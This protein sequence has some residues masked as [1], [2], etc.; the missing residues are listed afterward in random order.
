MRPRES[1]PRRMPDCLR[2][3]SMYQFQAASPE[4][5]SLRPLE[6]SSLRWVRRT[7]HLWRRCSIAA[8]F[9][10]TSPVTSPCVDS[11][12]GGAKPMPYQQRLTPDVSERRPRNSSKHDRI[13]WA[14]SGNPPPPA[15]GESE[16]KDAIFPKIGQGDSGWRSR[17]LFN[18][19]GS[20]SSRDCCDFAFS[21]LTVRSAVSRSEFFDG[22][23]ARRPGMQ[24]ADPGAGRRHRADSTSTH[25]FC[26]LSRRVAGAGSVDQS[27]QPGTRKISGET[28]SA[29]R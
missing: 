22:S 27:E 11:E 2:R 5:G 18:L 9:M 3:L 20:V 17:R 1:S 10:I 4:N 21:V 24:R 6:P 29:T 8:L 23:L 7:A 12:N 28:P 13:R 19:Y 14:R 16:P 15:A 25:R 26:C